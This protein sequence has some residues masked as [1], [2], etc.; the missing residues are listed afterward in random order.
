MQWKS[1]VTEPFQLTDAR[2]WIKHYFTN[3]EG[4][5]YT[6]DRF[7]AFLQRMGYIKAGEYTKLGIPLFL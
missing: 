3:N 1:E 6:V 2:K 5:V 4:N 7:I